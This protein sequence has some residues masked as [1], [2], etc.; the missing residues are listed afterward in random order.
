MTPDEL[1]DGMEHPEIAVALLAAEIEQDE[2][3]TRELCRQLFGLLEGAGKLSTIDVLEDYRDYVRQGMDKRRGA[4]ETDFYWY[5]ANAMRLEF[6]RLWPEYQEHFG[7]D[8][9]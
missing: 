2:D 9:D 6:C 3:K 4:E 1:L 5:E 7:R 8:D